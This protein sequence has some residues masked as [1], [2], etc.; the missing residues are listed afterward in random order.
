MGLEMVN[1]PTASS[2]HPPALGRR[3]AF[4]EG[5]FTDC[6]A[7]SLPQ[8]SLSTQ[9]PHGS[10]FYVVTVPV[11][12]IRE[13][14][15]RILTPSHYQ[16]SH[17]FCTRWASPEAELR[18]PAGQIAGAAR[19][20][21]LARC[22]VPGQMDCPGNCLLQLVQLEILLGDQVPPCGQTW[23]KGSILGP[24][25]LGLKKLASI[26]FN[27]RTNLIYSLRSQGLFCLTSSRGLCIG[28]RQEGL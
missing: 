22:S 18:M 13:Y 17:V 6:K 7:W 16:I 10:V 24:V 21:A 2:R 3:L 23:D 15:F 19:E 5:V 25:L 8:D 20:M 12:S 14:A 1:L 27:Q 11:T 28:P 26:H 9:E 4:P